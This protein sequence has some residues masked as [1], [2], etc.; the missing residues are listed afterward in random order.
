MTKHEGFTPGPWTAKP[1]CSPKDTFYI[2]DAAGHTL[3]GPG[4]NLSEA[5][6]KLIADAPRLLAE[7]ARLRR[8]IPLIERL[9]DE[10]IVGYENEQQEGWAVKQHQCEVCYNSAK[11]LRAALKESKGS[12]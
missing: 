7:N 9:T 12:A 6:A 10:V 4:Q 11:R 1:F 2:Q 3:V 8:L 5:N